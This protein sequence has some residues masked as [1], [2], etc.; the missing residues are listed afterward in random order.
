MNKDLYIKQIFSINDPNQKAYQCPEFEVIAFDY[1][2]VISTS[3]ICSTDL[4]H[5]NIHCPSDG[6][7][8]TN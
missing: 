1:T 7:S 5:T 8:N 3:L 6:D 4:C 2:D